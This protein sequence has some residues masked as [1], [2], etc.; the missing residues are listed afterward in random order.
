MPSSDMRWTVGK[1]GISLVERKKSRVL[2]SHVHV[3]MSSRHL[4]WATNIVGLF[5]FLCPL[6]ALHQLW[7]TLP[8]S[9]VNGISLH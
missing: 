5:L 6:P 2:F 1:E 9:D 7:V 4:H 8:R 3:D